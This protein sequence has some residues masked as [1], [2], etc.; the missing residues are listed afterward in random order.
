MRQYVPPNDIYVGNA[1]WEYIY[2]GTYSVVI[3]IGKSQFKYFTVPF[4]GY[5]YLRVW[6]DNSILLVHFL[7]IIVM[8]YIEQNQIL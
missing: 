5:D 3:F 6:Q 2:T 7:Q 4:F 1:L 8:N